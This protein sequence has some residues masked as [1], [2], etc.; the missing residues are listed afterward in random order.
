MPH[1]TAGFPVRLEKRPVLIAD[2]WM[3]MLAIYPTLASCSNICERG[4]LTG[5]TKD[6]TLN[7]SA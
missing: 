2:P 1:L 7:E 4:R 5:R 3:A 6:L